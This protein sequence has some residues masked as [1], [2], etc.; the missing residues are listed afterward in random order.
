[1]LL[2][3]KRKPM[4]SEFIGFLWLVTIPGPKLGYFNKVYIMK[5][6]L[7][8]LLL[9]PFSVVSQKIELHTDSV[10]DFRSN[11]SY[12]NGD[13]SIV[14]EYYDPKFWKFDLD[15]LWANCEETKSG[16][17]FS[18]KIILR[19]KDTYS[20]HVVSGNTHWALIINSGKLRLIEFYVDING[21]IK[22]K[23]YRTTIRSICY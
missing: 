10:F 5:S 12:T 8:F 3:F 6:L 18:K 15:S 9:F 20:F 17:K 13:L 4:R 16:K 1:M 7:I 19:E 22:G 2:P 11:L 14:K 23:I 21:K